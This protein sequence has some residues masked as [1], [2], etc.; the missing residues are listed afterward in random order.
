[1]D[2]N[3]KLIDNHESDRKQFEIE[4]DGLKPRIEY[5]LAKNTIYL[6]HTEVPTKLEGQGI[7][8][9]LVKSVLEDIKER[10]LTLVPLCPFV[11]MF[12]KRHPEW[13]ELVLKGINIA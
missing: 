10:G 2:N 11:A 5:I 1:M 6:T 8:T 9:Y 13:R 3:W 12:I 7:G 4:V